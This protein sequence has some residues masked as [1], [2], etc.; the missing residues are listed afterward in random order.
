MHHFD[1]M[2]FRWRG[3]CPMRHWRRPQ[4]HAAAPAKRCYRKEFATY[5]QFVVEK[6]STDG[7]SILGS[8]RFHRNIKTIK[9]TYS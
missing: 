7:T 8:A 4:R 2:T 9:Q 6:Q 1:Q 5:E 3:G